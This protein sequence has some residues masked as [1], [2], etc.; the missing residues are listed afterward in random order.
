MVELG[1]IENILLDFEWNFPSIVRL[2]FFMQLFMFIITL[3]SV[4]LVL[5]DGYITYRYPQFHINFGI[6]KANLFISFFV[7]TIARQII[8]IA[9]YQCYT[10]ENCYITQL[11]ILKDYY[12]FEILKYTSMIAF[13]VS[14]CWITCERIWA[15][16]YLKSYE[17][18]KSIKVIIIIVI[19]QWIAS[20]TA[21]W[22]FFNGYLPFLPPVIIGNL[23]YF[24]LAIVYY[25]LVAINRHRHKF[26]KYAVNSYSLSERFQVAENVRTAPIILSLLKVGLIL[27]TLQFFSAGVIFYS[28]ESIYKQ[29]FKLI[30]DFCLTIY[31]YPVI[32][33]IIFGVEKWRNIVLKFVFNFH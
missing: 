25:R 29:I 5:W 26:L 31:P 21:I 2:Y 27:N 9:T 11:Y 33:S 23:L 22:L 16:I 32:I 4:I 6:L 8:F 7:L 13:L 24:L 28:S 17:N 30:W 20:F 14:A 19:F 18:K 12:H 10:K 1:Y 15:N 3:I